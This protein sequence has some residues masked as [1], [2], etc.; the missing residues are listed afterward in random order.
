VDPGIFE[1][2]EAP[3]ALLATDTRPIRLGCVARFEEVEGHRYLI[4][5]CRPL[6]GFGLNFSCHLVGDGP[7]R[8]DIERRVK[9]AGL[10][11]RIHFRGSL[12]REEVAA[13]LRELEHHRDAFP[14]A[15]IRRTLGSTKM[16]M[17]A[18]AT[19]LPVI[20]SEIS[21][22]PELVQSGESGCLVPPRDPAALASAIQ[23]LASDFS[24]RRRLGTAGRH[25]F[26]TQFDIT[27]KAR[28]LA[29]RIAAIQAGS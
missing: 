11:K 3:Q 26:L 10:E 28:Q 18:M 7:L 8:R 20:A 12:S 24:L 5:A 14:A 13:F 1:P 22:I 4:E 19:E 16:S 2:I 25:R 6:E 15:V 17:E 23:S 29:S 9:A 21:G 27:T